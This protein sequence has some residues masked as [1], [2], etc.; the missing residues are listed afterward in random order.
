MSEPTRA[1]GET[2]LAASDI[3][4]YEVHGAR[5]ELRH[6]GDAIADDDAMSLNFKICAG[7]PTRRPATRHTHD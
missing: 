7:R 4:E 6:F 2:S 5:G 1:K 3:R